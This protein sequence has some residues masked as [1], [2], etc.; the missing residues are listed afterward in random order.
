MAS[1]LFADTGSLIGFA[2]AG[3]LETLLSQ[4]N[5]GRQLVITQEVLLELQ[6]SG[7][8]SST[9]AEQWAKS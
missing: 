5:G 1:Y 8:P 6:N 9:V 3:L 4:N 2:K 7:G